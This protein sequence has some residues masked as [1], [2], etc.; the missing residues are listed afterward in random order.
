VGLR[1][2]TGEI[3]DLGVAAQ[4]LLVHDDMQVCARRQLL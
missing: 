4:I 3:A 2:D 1:I